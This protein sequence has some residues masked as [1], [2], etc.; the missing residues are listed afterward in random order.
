MHRKTKS[1][2]PELEVG[3]RKA[4]RRK[5]LP[6]NHEEVGELGGRINSC[7]NVK[8]N[9]LLEALGIEIQPERGASP[10][11]LS[12]EILPETEINRRPT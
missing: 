4:I 9:S 10:L 1:H 3:L 7:M 11:K 2:R 6:K 5:Q 8:N 12:C